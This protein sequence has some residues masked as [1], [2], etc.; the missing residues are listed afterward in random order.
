[1][2]SVD[3]SLDGIGAV[4]SQIKEGETRARPIAFASKSLSQSQKNYPA[5]RL[6][7]LALKWAICEKFSHWLKGHVF[8]VWTDNNPLTHIMTKPKLDCCEQRWVAKLAGYSFDIKY[9]PGPQNFVAD[10]LSR[11]PFVKE[12]VSSGYFRSLIPPFSLRSKV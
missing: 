1:M 4:L 9:V 7:F 6:E 3:A 11:V 8:T 5:H 12:R 2:L 10:A